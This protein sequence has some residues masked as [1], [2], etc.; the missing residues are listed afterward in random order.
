MAVKRGG[1]IKRILFATATV[2]TVAL[3]C[4]AAV[5]F[6]STKAN[7]ETEGIYTYTVR[8]GEAIITACDT[9]ASGDITISDTLGGYPVTGIG[10]KAFNKVINI[11]T[12]TIPDSVINIGE[13]AF[14]DCANLNQIMLGNSVE[15]IGARAFDGSCYSL[16]KIAVDKSNQNYSND[17]NGVLFNKLKTE[18]I[19]YPID[20][21]LTEYEIPDSVIKIGDFSFSSSA[22]LEK[23]IIPDSVVDIGNN[24]FSSC[25]GFAEISIPDSVKAIGENAFYWCNN[26]KSINLPYGLKNIEKCTFY[27]CTSLEKINI[28]YGVESIGDYAFYYCNAITDISLPNSITSIG[29]Y[30]FYECKSILDLSIPNSVTRIGDYAFYKCSSLEKMDIPDSVIIIGKRAFSDCGIMSIK[31]GKGLSEIGEEALVAGRITVDDDNPNYSSDNYG[32]LF[33]K[34]K[35]V[36]IRLPLF[37]EITTYSIPDTVVAIGNYACVADNLNNILIPKSVKS[38]G[39]FAFSGSGLTEITIPDS[40]KSLGISAFESCLKLESA[41]VGNGVEKIEDFAFCCCTCLKRVIIGSSIKSIGCSAFESCEN[42]LSIIIPDSVESIKDSA[43]YDCN[44]LESVSLGKRLKTIGN[45]AFER[46][47]AIKELIIPDSV[48]S[49][50]ANAFEACRSLEKLVIGNGLTCIT[51]FAFSV[52]I[53]LKNVTLSDSVTSV[54]KWAFW[55]CKKIEDV[56]FS[57]DSSKWNSIVVGEE[58]QSLINSNIH[59]LQT[60]MLNYGNETKSISIFSGEPIEAIEAPSKEGYVFDCWLDKNGDTVQIPETMP[61]MNL[62]FTA[63]WTPNYYDAVFNANGGKWADGLSEKKVSTAFDSA[64]EA[65]ETPNKQGYIFSGWSLN[66]ENIGTLPGN[67]DDVNGKKYTAI[68]I[69]ATDT[70]YKVITYTM[71]TSGKYEE[72]VQ[73]LSGTTDEEISAEMPE[74]PEGFSLNENASTL[75]GVIAA[76]NSLILKIYIDRNIYTVTVINDEKSTEHKYFYGQAVSEPETPMKDGN[77]FDCWLDENG[78]KAQIPEIMPAENIV[79]TAKYKK[80]QQTNGISVLYDE[81]AFGKDVYLIADDETDTLSPEVI[82][83][84]KLRISGEKTWSNVY[85]ISFI[86]SSGHTVKFK[87]GQKV[88]V[89]IPIPESANPNDRFV[90]HHISS[91]EAGEVPQKISG[92][93]IRQE[94]GYLIFDVTHFSYFVLCVDRTPVSIRVASTPNKTSYFY[95]ID[96]SLDLSGLAIEVTYDD[97]STETV[98]DT[99]LMNFSG[100]DSKKT[101]E[102]TVTVEYGGLSAGFTVNV[103]YAWWQWIIK[104]LLL[105]FL[106]Y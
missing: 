52:C 88:T 7:A 40:V 29:N 60:I 70:V 90:I 22:K 55:N 36:L 53:N 94:N 37:S 24:A 74:I 72:S 50:G 13:F 97:G 79:L 64:I 81:E 61:E 45:D 93:Q 20:N 2:M 30:S 71:N 68:W 51:E 54:E 100:F 34:D 77:V 41:T 33:N 98:T 4:A 19:R 66:G 38:I 5:L 27:H 91:I 78:E 63:L 31:V 9:N 49:I 95:K 62:T 101:G 86:D 103:K 106:W 8:N 89:S 48:T 10:D 69:P 73:I 102:Q 39:D 47:W 1:R 23:I 35:T 75:K 12:V 65:P 21:I 11:R 105:G 85:T 6:S 16:K 96:N 46:N 80:I 56:Y 15:H 43:F 26:L 87:D 58:N 42:L 17:E 28:P 99:A 44:N 25:R 32:A 14:L 76:D 84:L 18:L 92:S 3:V 67:M 104:I 83:E 59:F 57:G 82:A